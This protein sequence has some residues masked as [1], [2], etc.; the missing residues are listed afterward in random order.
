[1]TVR[2]LWVLLTVPWVGLQRVIVVFPDH[3]HLLVYVSYNHLHCIM[4][5]TNG[6]VSIC[7]YING[8][9]NIYMAVV[10]T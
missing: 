6:I 1:M 9:S 2:V 7:Q 10:V 3:T 8:T 5:Q 4:G